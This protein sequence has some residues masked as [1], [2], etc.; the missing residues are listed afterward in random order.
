MT[1]VSSTSV[2]LPPYRGEQP[3]ANE[4][5]RARSHKVAM[6]TGSSEAILFVAYSSVESR[7]SRQCSEKGAMEVGKEEK[8]ISLGLASVS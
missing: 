3:H 2:A 8:V 6:T 4:N 7:V 5:M 1:N